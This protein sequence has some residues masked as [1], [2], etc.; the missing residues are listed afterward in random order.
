[1]ISETIWIALVFIDVAFTVWFF[2][3]LKSYWSN[4]IVAG[5]TYLLSTG[6]SSMMVAGIDSNGAV[7]TDPWLATIFSWHSYLM[8]ALCGLAL[9]K[10]TVLSNDQ[11]YRKVK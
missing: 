1:M 11:P 4:I 10:N 5:M 9:L 6:L 7:I 3:D 2:L 8:L